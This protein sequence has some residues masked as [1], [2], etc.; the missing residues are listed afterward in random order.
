LLGTPFN[1]PSAVSLPYPLKLTPKERLDFYVPPHS[2]NLYSL[3]TNPMVLFG[4]GGLVLFALNSLVDVN[5]L[6]EAAK[7]T[8]E[9]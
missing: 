5:A 9:M 2:F 7:Q 6:Q 8:E 4:I 3:L 1:P